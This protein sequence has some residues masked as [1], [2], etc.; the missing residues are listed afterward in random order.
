[1]DLF[2]FE[3][4]YQGRTPMGATSRWDI[5]AAQHAIAALA[6]SGRIEGP[7]LDAGCGTGEHAIMLAE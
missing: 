4:I 2:N 5:G 6:A 3:A 7:V 1:M